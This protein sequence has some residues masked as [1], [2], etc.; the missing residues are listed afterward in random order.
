MVGGGWPCDG[1]VW[2]L[3]VRVGATP[4]QGDKCTMSGLLSQPNDSIATAQTDVGCCHRQGIWLYDMGTS[5][6]PSGSPC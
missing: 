5:E 2:L 4:A 3:S 1:I 6:L